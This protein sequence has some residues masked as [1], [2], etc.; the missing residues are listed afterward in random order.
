VKPFCANRQFHLWSKSWKLGAIPL[1]KLVKS[2][3]HYTDFLCEL[4]TSLLIRGIQMG[5]MSKL[6]W[7]I[8]FLK[9][10]IWADSLHF[11]PSFS[12]SF[13]S[14]HASSQFLLHIFLLS[15][16]T[17]LVS[18]IYIAV[19]LLT[20]VVHWLRLALSK[21]PSWID[22]SPPHQRMDTD[23]FSETL[24][25]LDFRIPVDGESPKPQYFWVLMVLIYFLVILVI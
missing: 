17:S 6:G 21:G 23:P 14:V 15:P 5:E 7:L 11:H 8:G 1:C 24:C 9:H 13:R 20:W 10:T 4:V 22:I 3:S 18:G 2:L 25:S 16:F 12:L 19:V